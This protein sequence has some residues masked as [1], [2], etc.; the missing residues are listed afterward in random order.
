MATVGGNLLQ[1]TRCHYFY[2]TTTACNKRTPGAGCAALTG[3]TRNHAILGTSD[4]CLATHPSDLCVA[5]A[6][7]DAVVEVESTEGTRHIPITDFHTLPGNTP[8]VETTL[9][10][11]E[12]ITAIELPNLPVAA[13]SRYRKVRDRASY[14]FALVSVAAALKVEDNTVTE[15]RLALGGVA[16]KP[17]RA[18]K[19]EQTLIGKPATEASFAEAAETELATATPQPDNA[20]KVTLAQRAIVATLRQLSTEG[21]AA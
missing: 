14:A 12:L 21:T 7:L 9:T 5:L 3:F 10:A 11:N 15:A 19:A 13:T 4:T 16:A 1:R 20:F 6:A 18:T 8:N 2:D 17:W